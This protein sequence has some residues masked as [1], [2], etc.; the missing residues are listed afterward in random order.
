MG[1]VDHDGDGMCIGPQ[2]EHCWGVF[3]AAGLLLRAPAAGGTPLILMQH[4]AEWTNAGGTWGLPGGAIDSHESPIEGALREVH[5]ETHIALNPARARWSAPT[6]GMR[7]VKRLT[8]D[9]DPLGDRISRSGDHYFERVDTTSGL[10]TYTTVVADL[11]APVDF[12]ADEESKE[13]AWLSEDEV[14]Q[15]ELIPGFGR[16]WPALKTT[17]ADLIIDGESIYSGQDKH[18]WQSDRSRADSILGKIAK[19]R[20]WVWRRRHATDFLDADGC[21]Q[22][23]TEPGFYWTAHCTVVLGGKITGAREERALPYTAQSYF[24]TVDSDSDS[25]SLVRTMVLENVAKR[26][27]TIVVTENTGLIEELP[28]N[29]IHVWDNSCLSQLNSSQSLSSQSRSAGSSSSS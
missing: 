20:P 11:N 7:F 29:F 21:A 13:L 14:S 12:Q 9:F 10:W 15:L 8:R 17:E 5:E 1:T 24:H 22:E 27:N 6:A 4:R 18:W 19:H 23:T 2:D 28:Q 16:V 26:R 25:A 3:G